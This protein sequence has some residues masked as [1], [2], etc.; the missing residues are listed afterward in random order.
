MLNISKLSLIRNDDLEANL[1]LS[2]QELRT[3][4]LEQAEHLAEHAMDPRENEDADEV[5]FKEFEETIVP[6]VFAL[7]CTAIMLFLAACEERVRQRLPTRLR[8][9]EARLRHRMA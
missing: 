9:Q 3:R 1:R 4:L 7:A 5:L 6:M 8:A 2:T